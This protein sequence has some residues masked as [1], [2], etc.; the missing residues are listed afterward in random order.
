VQIAGLDFRGLYH[1]KPDLQSALNEIFKN[2]TAISTKISF[3]INRI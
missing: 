1:E 2:I 3:E